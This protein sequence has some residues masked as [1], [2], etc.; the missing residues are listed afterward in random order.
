[1]ADAVVV[2]NVFDGINFE[3]RRVFVAKGT[4][5]PVVNSPNTRRLKPQFREKLGNRDGLGLFSVHIEEVKKQLRIRQIQ[6]RTRTLF[7]SPVAIT[8]IFVGFFAFECVALSGA[9]FCSL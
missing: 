3:G 7:F 4:C 9:N 1:M 2:P 5:V 8:A 6:R